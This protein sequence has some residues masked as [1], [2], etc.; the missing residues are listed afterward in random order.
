MLRFWQNVIAFITANKTTK[1]ILLMTCLPLQHVIQINEN[2]PRCALT[3]RL[4]TQIIFTSQSSLD[5]N[6]DQQF[7]KKLWFSRKIQNMHN[8]DYS[9]VH[10]ILPQRIISIVIF[11]MRF[12]MFWKTSK[13]LPDILMR[14][15]QF[16]KM[17]ALN[18]LIKRHI[19]RQMAH[20]QALILVI[21]NCWDKT[22]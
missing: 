8:L 15:G 22:K 9:K 14:W 17:M 19:C 5:K 1:E 21:T 6:A 4:P 10:V 13:V 18:T 3:E 12:L 2:M 16:H 7:A 11:E 20:P